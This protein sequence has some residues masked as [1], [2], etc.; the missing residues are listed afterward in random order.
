[1]IFGAAMAERANTPFRGQ[2]PHTPET[3][4]VLR[5]AY[6]NVFLGISS[7]L[8]RGVQNYLP[9]PLVEEL[10]N[11]FGED[12][13]FLFLSGIK[14]HLSLMSS[15]EHGQFHSAY[16]EDF[17]PN[18][19]DLHFGSGI[20]Y[21]NAA[22]P[23]SG[24]S[25]S[26]ILGTAETGRLPQSAPLSLTFNNMA[27]LQGSSVS[28]PGLDLVVDRINYL[29]F[30]IKEMHILP[31]AADAEGL[32]RL[33]STVAIGGRLSDIYLPEEHRGELARLQ[34]AHPQIRFHV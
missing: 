4:R 24:I 26:E 16:L 34:S 30:K 25:A 22:F 14:V 3:P 18:H 8:R 9:Y 15:G 28:S 12:R 1:M 27:Q 31:G 7:S 2:I 17:I 32:R 20:R 23:N 11:S 19:R 6:K 10:A 21:F 29:S 13:T 5:E 33:I